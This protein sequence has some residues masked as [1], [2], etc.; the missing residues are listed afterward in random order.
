MPSSSLEEAFF[1]FER[2]LDKQF[3]DMEIAA[4]INSPSTSPA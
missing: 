3:K 4:D 1:D 2:A